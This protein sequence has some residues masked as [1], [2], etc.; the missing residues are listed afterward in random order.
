[1]AMNNDGVEVGVVIAVN[2]GHTLLSGRVGLLH[3]TQAP[4]FRENCKSG[5]G[6]MGILRRKKGGGRAQ[7]SSHPD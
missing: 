7:T 4:G 3:E 6:W 5:I 2:A 1:M